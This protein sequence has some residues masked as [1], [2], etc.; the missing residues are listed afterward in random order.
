MNHESRIPPLP[1]PDARGYYPALA[2]AYALIARDVI[3]RRRA[4]KLTQAELAARAGVRLTTV[5]RL[6]AAEHISGEPLLVKIEAA[7]ERAN[8]R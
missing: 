1:E 4:A 6:E 7:L 5:Q 3:R 2:T 8:K